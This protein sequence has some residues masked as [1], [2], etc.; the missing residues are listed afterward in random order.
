MTKKSFEILKTFTRKLANCRYRVAPTTLIEDL[1]SGG[2]GY[3]VE[4]GFK[5]PSYTAM[6]LKGAEFD[7]Y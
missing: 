2:F 4:E 5:T 1:K 7:Q 3:S 6:L